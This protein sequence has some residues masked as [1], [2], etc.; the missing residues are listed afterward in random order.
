MIDTALIW[1]LIIGLGLL[2]YVVLDGFDLGIGILFPFVKKEQE[3]DVMMNTVAPVWDGNETWMVLGGA[4]LYA[5]FPVVYATVLSALYIPISLMAITLIF[6]GVTF[7]FR[8][9]SV[10]NKK[11]WDYSFIFGSTCSSFLQGVI[12]GAIIQGIETTNGIY[13]GGTFDWLTPFTLFTGVGVVVMYATLGCAWLIFKTEGDLQQTMFRIMPKV[14]ALLFAV[15]VVVLIVSP[16]IEPNFAQRWFEQPNVIYFAMMLI[17]T[18]A[19]FWLLLTACK[20]RHDKKPFIYTFLLLL[21]AFIG[22]VLS[23]FPY[24]IPP[25]VDIWQASAPRSSQM[26]ALVGAGIFIPIILGYTILSYW[27]FRDK[28]RIGDEGYH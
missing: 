1:F 16:I 2:I 12:L 25:T 14:T 17:A 20:Q 26:F 24:I 19:I 15:F 18:L 21:L 11:W 4:G 10:N 3:R 13:S 9:K 5:A 7:K 6:R 8:S 22:F 23:L 28:V 27:V